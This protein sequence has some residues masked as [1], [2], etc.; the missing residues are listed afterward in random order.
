[1]HLDCE[2]LISVFASTKARRRSFS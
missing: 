2:N 1:M